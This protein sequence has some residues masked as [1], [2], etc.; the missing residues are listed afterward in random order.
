[1]LYRRLVWNRRGIDPRESRTPSAY[2]ALRRLFGTI[3]TDRGAEFLD[4]EICGSCFAVKR[5]ALIDIS[6]AGLLRL[7][8]QRIPHLNL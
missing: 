4:Y 6:F 5:Q 1:M 3:L 7:V 8:W 2:T